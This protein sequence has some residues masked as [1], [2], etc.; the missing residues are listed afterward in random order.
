M[1]MIAWLL[2]QDFRHLRNLG[3]QEMDSKSLTCGISTKTAYSSQLH[4]KQH[5][6]KSASWELA[7]TTVDFTFYL[8][9]IF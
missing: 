7:D 3:T 9:I 6:R 5:M 8:K 2:I 1:E 4:V